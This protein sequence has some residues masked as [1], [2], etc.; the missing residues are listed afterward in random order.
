MERHAQGRWVLAAVVG[1]AAIA[2]VLFV[3]ALIP[4]PAGRRVAQIG[5]RSN[6]RPK[7]RTHL[8]PNPE[9]Q[10]KGD[11]PETEDIPTDEDDQGPASD[12]FDWPAEQSF[13]LSDFQARLVVGGYV[14]ALLLDLQAGRLSRAEVASRF[15]PGDKQQE[16]LRT[17]CLLHLDELR[18]L[19]KELGV[20]SDTG[21]HTY[22]IERVLKRLVHRGLDLARLRVVGARRTDDPLGRDLLVR[23]WV[24]TPL[25][26]ARLGLE[27]AERFARWL[28]EVGLGPTDG[29]RRLPGGHGYDALCLRDP[30]RSALLGRPIPRWVDGLTL[31]WDGVSVMRRTKD[32]DLLKRLLKHQLLHNWRAA[33]RPSW[34]GSL[35][36]WPRGIFSSEGIAAYLSWSRP[37]PS[38]STV[39]LERLRDDM[40]SL[41]EWIAWME[42]RT[43]QPLDLDLRAFVGCNEGLFH[44]YAPFSVLLAQ[45]CCA[46]LGTEQVVR[47]LGPD[48]TLRFDDGFPGKEAAFERAIASIDWRKLRAF[49]SEAGAGGRAAASRSI[50]ARTTHGSLPLADFERLPAWLWRDDARKVGLHVHPLWLVERGRALPSAAAL[51]HPGQIKRVGGLLRRFAADGS[52]VFVTDATTEMQGAFRP[53]TSWADAPPALAEPHASDETRMGFVARWLQSIAAD[54]PGL[55]VPTFAAADSV[56][57]FTF[58][59]LPDENT[60]SL[61]SV[62]SF[63]Q[64]NR[65]SAKGMIICLASRDPDWLQQQ[66]GWLAAEGVLGA[67]ASPSQVEEAFIR[68]YSRTMR[69]YRGKAPRSVLIV[70]MAG[71]STQ[72]RLIARAW[73]ASALL[74]EEPREIAY[75][76]PQADPK[77][78]EDRK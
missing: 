49:I 20:T 24:R 25:E 10:N 3:A 63:V 77:A 69:R 4:D 34:G 59:F 18:A 7:L 5:D 76:D 47:A 15:R 72:A 75:W 32:A 26:S 41:T 68:M 16:Q 54:S 42:K 1:T 35:G 52:L 56:T 51:E 78:E 66:R 38:G 30:G 62:V 58:P 17:Y 74:D 40:A 14:R 71:G 44:S 55:T 73:A 39:P 31:P 11:S 43:G 64:T 8:G 22:P 70:D 28:E 19:E 21:D 29:A 27:R 46:Y 2:V 48:D 57:P 53:A 12:R 37:A 13:G 65:T 50:Q 60:L 45:A 67:D 36:G 23:V 33:F 61:R 6:E 9:P